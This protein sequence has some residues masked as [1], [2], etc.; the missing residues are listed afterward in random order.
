MGKL[1]L[2]MPDLGKG[3]SSLD[4]QAKA[5]E[6]RIRAQVPKDLAGSVRVRTVRTKERTVLEIE[7]DDRAEQMVLVAIE[8]PKGSGKEECVVPDR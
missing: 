1:E 3:A 4:S 8:Y 7:F 6:K 2:P 5:L